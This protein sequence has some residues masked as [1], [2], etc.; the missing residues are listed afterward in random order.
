M[1]KKIKECHK[2]MHILVCL[3]AVF[4]SVLSVF[5]IFK[6]RNE[7]REY[8]Y[9]GRAP[10]TQYTVS[11]DGEGKVSGKPDVAVINLGVQS[12]AKTVK[13]AQNDNTKKM[14]AIVQAVKD[15]GVKA[16]D[17]QTANYS[18][19]PKYSY[20]KD[21]GASDII[22]YTVSQSATVKVRDL[23]KTGAIL[24]T[25]GELGANTVGGVQF[26]IDNPEALK[27]Q[28]REKAIDNAKKKASELFKKLGVSAGRIVSFSENTGGMP[29]YYK[30]YE[31][32]GIGGGAAS[33]PQ[34]ESGSLDIVVNVGLVFEI[35]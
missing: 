6:I 1:F 14:N 21:T 31:S 22:G 35:K 5:F 10:L 15:L 8:G 18:I 7:S 33:A 9:I 12:D 23:D 19:Y 25:A 3:A 4:L 34:I 2:K 24:G 27:E 32:M 20:N 29:I 13:D 28:A 16:E 17:I 30:G 26:T 11:I